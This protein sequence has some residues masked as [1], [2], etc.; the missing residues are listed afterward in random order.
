MVYLRKKELSKIF[1]IVFKL[2]FLLSAIAVFMMAACKK[3]S[4]K[5][6]TP[7][8]TPPSIPDG[9]TEIPPYVQ[10]TSGDATRGWDYLRYENYIV[11][12]LPVSLFLLAGGFFDGEK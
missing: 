7:S 2:L 4:E 11:A 5:D 1:T 10:N 3:K 8:Q 6:L 9:A 12:G